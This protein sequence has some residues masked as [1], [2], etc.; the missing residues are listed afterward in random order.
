MK[1]SAILFSVLALAVVVPAASNA[2]ILPRWDDTGYGTGE[3]P[4]MDVMV[5]G[6][7]YKLNGRM[8]RTVL[9]YNFNFQGTAGGMDVRLWGKMDSDPS[10][11]YGFSATNTTNATHTFFV[12]FS[13]ATV[14]DNYD[15]ALSSFSA[16]STDGSD[17]GVTATPNPGAKMHHAYINGQS[18]SGALGVDIGDACIDPSGGSTSITYNFADISRSFAPVS[19][20]ELDV[21]LGFDLSSHDAFTVNGR[22]DLLKTGDIPT[23]EP[24]SLALMGGGLLTYLAS[25]RRRK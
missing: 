1:R 24:N 25:R 9:G 6:H 12:P 22:T 16:S 4:T 3:I 13:V 23:P 7:A 19:A 2:M 10:L 20:S 21:D 17:D 15:H 8:D 14:V 5:D 18:V 11:F